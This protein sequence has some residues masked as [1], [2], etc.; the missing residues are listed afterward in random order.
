M[1]ET[2]RLLLP[3]LAEAQDSPEIPVNLGR[4]EVDALLQASVIRRDLSAPP[5]AEQEGDAFIVNAPGSGAWAGHDDQIAAFQGG[6]YR[7]Y[8]PHDGWR[9]WCV[10][11]AKAIRFGVGSPSTWT[12]DQGELEVG[13]PGS[14]SFVV[15]GVAQILF[16]GADVTDL[17]DGTVLVEVGVTPG[18][19]PLEI[20]VA[21]S[22][23]TT[24]ITTGVGKAYVRAP[25]AF[26]L[27]EVRAS[28]FAASSSG[29]P[30]VDVNVNGSS[31]LSTKLT[32]DQGE[33]TSV[34]AATPAV[35]S[36]PTIAD[37]DEITFDID[38][39]G[40]AAAGLIV[41]LIGSG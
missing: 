18:G 14:P 26:T 10:A 33:K 17:G 12:I 40:T 39:A 19:D 15:P 29:A 27:S 23:M 36:A 13:I 31:I 32:I 41:T 22:D 6:G 16:T 24:A 34:T 25:R 8:Q 1:A 20:Q 28:L 7:Y 21:L 35:I 11:E 9:V 5:G 38:T 37:D 3:L 30:Q 4:Y 2:P